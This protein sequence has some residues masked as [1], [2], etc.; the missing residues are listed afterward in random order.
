MVGNREET[1]FPIPFYFMF[2]IYLRVCRVCV[3]CIICRYVC[4]GCVLY[5]LYVCRGGGSACHGRHVEIRRQCVRFLSLLC[6]VSVRDGTQAVR[7][8]SKHLYPANPLL[9][10]N[11]SS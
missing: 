6:H 5:V 11:V 7:L 1:D 10:P 8:D 4:V 9:G 2:Y 3:V